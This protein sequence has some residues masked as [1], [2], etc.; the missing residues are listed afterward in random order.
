MVTGKGAAQ[1][2]AEA[3][4]GAELRLMGLFNGQRG[5]GAVSA[6]RLCPDVLD[7]LR[8]DPAFAEN[9]KALKAT[10]ANKGGA[11]RRTE[12]GG[13]L[14]MGLLGTLPPSVKVNGLKCCENF[15]RLQ[16]FREALKAKNAVKFQAL[17][18]MLTKAL[19]K[20][21]PDA[22]GKNGSQLLHGDPA[23][24]AFELGVLQLMSGGAR[25]DPIHFDGG[26]SLLL[27][28]IT[29]W[30]NRIT[31]FLHDCEPAAHAAQRAVAA[32]NAAKQAAPNAARQAVAAPK[33]KT[34]FRRAG[35]LR[36]RRKL[37]KTVKKAGSKAAQ[38]TVHQAVKQTARKKPA[39][40]DGVEDGS[41]TD[42]VAGCKVYIKK[43]VRQPFVTYFFT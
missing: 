7:W 9:G 10:M 41:L 21:P 35:F 3:P 6:G 24:W 36:L 13:K 31:H 17:G 28:G 5:P 26:A 1:V 39:A 4:Q 12:E 27:L 15:D 40:A 29:L 33:K 22:L 38:A 42:M 18:T 43:L 11:G 25:C 37:K 16:I 19:Q 30:G 8:A 32:P 14:E 20:L 2:F 34:G 23:S